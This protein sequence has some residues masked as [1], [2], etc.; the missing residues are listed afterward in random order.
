MDTDDRVAVFR[1]GGMRAIEHGWQL[2][3]MVGCFAIAQAALAGP[4][5][6]ILT[7]ADFNQ[8]GV[9]DILAENLVDPN[10]GLLQTI[11]IDSSTGL[12]MGNEF[13]I[14]LQDGYEFLAVGNFNGNLE[15]QSQIAARKMSGTPT[16]ELGGVR[17]WDLTDDASAPAGLIEGELVFIPEPAYKL[18]GIG[19]LDGNGVD[20][21]VFVYDDSDAGKDQGLVRVY[22][23]DIPI[24]TLMRVMRIAHPL[25]VSDFA[26]TL[27]IFGVADADGNGTADFI[28]ASRDSSDLFP[29]LRILLM[30]VDDADGVRV[31]DQKFPHGLP[32]TVFDFLGFARIDSGSS[33]DLVFS[34][35]TS[36]NQGVIQV[37]LL[38]QDAEN[39]SEPFYPLNL[40]SSYDYIGNGLFDGDT[41]TDLILIKRYTP[42]A[43]LVRLVLLD[44]V[45]AD[46]S[47][48]IDI[49]DQTAGPIK[50]S[51]FPTLLTPRVWQERSSPSGTS[52]LEAP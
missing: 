19:D 30:Q 29:N 17:L 41:D 2:V 32:P 13:P 1:E 45:S 37:R 12:P 9:T 35:R 18:V 42:N 51:V 50:S 27:E 39:L 22:L 38:L 14:R 5:S 6:T 7:T 26:D 15:G 48:V 49:K 16:D 33:A 52:D 20:D 44:A 34:K 31:S 8:D 10:A 4:N 25:N 21:F 28:F 11:L 23:M 47:G 40:G 36:P 46:P 24:D 43:G 3:A